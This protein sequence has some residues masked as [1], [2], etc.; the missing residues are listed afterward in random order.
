MA[1]LGDAQVDNLRL[2][3]SERASAVEA[4]LNDAAA[5]LGG[6]TDSRR[7]IFEAR[8]LH[9]GRLT[10]ARTMTKAASCHFS[11]SLKHK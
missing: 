8:R 6:L 4:Q 7:R 11:L 5:A 9:E 1:S 2:Y 3:A 10:E